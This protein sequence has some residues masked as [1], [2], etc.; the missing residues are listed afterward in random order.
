MHR[1]STTVDL[2]GKFSWNILSVTVETICPGCIAY[3]KD[4]MAALLSVMFGTFVTFSNSIIAAL[5][6]ARK[7]SINLYSTTCIC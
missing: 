6:R 5:V 4:A 1:R 3:L 2:P 7:Q